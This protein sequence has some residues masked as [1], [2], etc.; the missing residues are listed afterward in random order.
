MHLL[1]S[2]L[3]DMLRPYVGKFVV[4]Y[5]DDILIL[6]KTAAEHLSHLRQVL[7]TLG[8][9]KFYSPEK[10]GLYEG[11]DSFPGSSG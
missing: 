10:V 11:R 3:N 2:N 7:Q 1:L 6:S 5:L 4:M 9:N 8:E